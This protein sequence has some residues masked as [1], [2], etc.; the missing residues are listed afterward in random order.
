MSCDP[1]TL[2]ADGKCFDCLSDAQLETIQTQ[3]LC[4]ISVLGVAGD[5]KSVNNLS[6]VASVSTSRTNL[7][8]GTGNSPVFTGLTLSGLTQGS[9]LFAGAAGVISQ[10]NTNFYWDDTAKNLKIGGSPSF[11]VYAF[12]PKAISTTKSYA[13]NTGSVGGAFFPCN[14]YNEVI[15]TGNLNAGGVVAIPVPSVN[16]VN[17]TNSSGTAYILST[18]GNYCNVSAGTVSSAAYGTDNE[19]YISGNPTILLGSAVF[20]TVTLTSASATVTTLAGTITDVVVTA[21][22]GTVCYGAL[23]KAAAGGT[24]TNR[25]GIYLDLRH[26]ATIG[27][28]IKAAATPTG[29]LIQ[30]L[31]S[32]SNKKLF[33][34]SAF[35]INQTIDRGIFLTNQTDQAAAQAGTLGNA[36]V[37]GNPA[38]WVPIKVNGT[39]R[40]FPVW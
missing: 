23:I 14:N 1:T 6:D 22:T 39:N 29:D 19:L 37:A 15:V 21:G 12:V 36:P 33:V 5:L 10:D 4:D 7:G 11:P 32:G 31:D 9:V 35:V 25:Y 8:L 38:F 27:T 30:L 3:L 40:S 17:M 13:N 24:F 2:L 34:D 20:N 28:V 18:M 16:V 26:A